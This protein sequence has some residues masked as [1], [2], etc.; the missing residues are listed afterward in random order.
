MRPPP[1]SSASRSPA[2]ASAASR[3]GRALASLAMVPE[4]RA[5]PAA[6]AH[7]SPG[8]T[9]GAAPS[10]P[11]PWGPRRGRVSAR[12]SRASGSIFLGTPRI[13]GDS[14]TLAFVTH[15]GLSTT[16]CRGKRTP[17]PSS[18]SGRPNS[19]RV[20]STTLLTLQAPTPVLPAAAPSAWA[21]VSYPPRSL[22]P[23]PSTA[24]RPQ[25]CRLCA[26]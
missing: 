23:S 14:P 26:V 18:P 1:V 5:S 8:H 19:S 20:R 13:P 6:G 3:A 24:Q 7:K 25:H 17:R 15:S 11:P 22:A 2:P 4:Q 21:L 9:Q 16:R 12:R 10:P